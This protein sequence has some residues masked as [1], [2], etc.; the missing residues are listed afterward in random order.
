VA[1]LRTTICGADTHG[2][3]IIGETVERLLNGADDE[4]IAKA[5]L[6]TLAEETIHT[7]SHKL[8]EGVIAFAFAFIST[9]RLRGVMAKG[10]ARRR[11][12]RIYTRAVSGVS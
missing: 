8:K 12:N 6:L 1:L 9:S 5:G 4:S 11:D 10:V 7:G 2:H 3:T